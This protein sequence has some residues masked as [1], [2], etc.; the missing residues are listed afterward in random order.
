MGHIIFEEGIQVDP[1]K[2]NVISKLP[3]PS[4]V[5]KVKSFLGH[6]GFYRWFIKNFSKI[7]LPLSNLLQKDVL[8]DFGE[9][10][11]EAF[12]AL[13]AALVTPPIINALD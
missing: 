6:A 13:K 1:A 5:R 4:S 10:C 8:F 9:G 12:D 7:T 2:L 3:Y 11:K